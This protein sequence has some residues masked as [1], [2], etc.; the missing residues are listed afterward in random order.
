MNPRLPLV[1]AACAAF[2]IA[3]PRAQRLPDRGRIDAAFAQVVAQP[4]EARWR[5]IDWRRS[6]RVALAEARETGKPVYYFG[7]DGDFFAGNC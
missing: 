4:R 5:L 7:A 2:L 1:G 3:A 6:L